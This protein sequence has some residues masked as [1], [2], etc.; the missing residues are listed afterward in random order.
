MSYQR[1][2][3]PIP[4]QYDIDALLKVDIAAPYVAVNVTNTLY[5]VIETLP[6]GHY[7]FR[8]DSALLT[9]EVVVRDLCNFDMAM[10]NGFHACLGYGGGFTCFFRALRALRMIQHQK[11]IALAEAVRDV[12]VANGAREPASFADDNQEGTDV[13]WDEDLKDM[14]AFFNRI[15]EPIRHLDK[16][17]DGWHDISYTYWDRRNQV[18]V[19]ADPPWHYTVC[20]YLATHRDLLRC[21]KGCHVA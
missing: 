13:D 6:R 14:E 16:V 17:N 10:G 20:V 18:L 7:S 4:P 15:E 2:P 12:L 19:P 3:C 1:I 9:P 21:R 8:P 11:G 5:E